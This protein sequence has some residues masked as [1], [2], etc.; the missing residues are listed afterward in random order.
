MFGIELIAQAGHVGGLL[1]GSVLGWALTRDRR[2]FELIGWAS[3]SVAAVGLGLVG[4]APTWRANY[5][6]F[7]GFELLERGEFERAAEAFEGGLA[8]APD[9]PELANAVAWALVEAGV[10]LDRAEVLVRDALVREP[11]RADFLDTLGWVLCKQGR[12]AE[13]AEALEQA[14]AIDPDMP[15]IEEH[16]EQCPGVG[17]FHV[18]PSGT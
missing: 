3:T 11:D 14:R 8:M 2:A 16:L 4:Q 9:D 1:A 7:T 6:V 5:H 18:E 15:E 17:M 13:G 10:E 12:A